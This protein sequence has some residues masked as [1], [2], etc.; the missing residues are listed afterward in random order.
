MKKCLPYILVAIITFALAIG[1]RGQATKGMDWSEYFPAIPNC[2]QIIYPLYTDGRGN[3]NQSARYTLPPLKMS[4][5]ILIENPDA[6]RSRPPDC[7][8]IQIRMFVPRLAIKPPKEKTKTQNRSEKTDKI[9]KK[10]DKIL[11]KIGSFYPPAPKPR[12][13]TIN[14]FEATQF[15]QARTDTYDIEPTLTTIEV[16]LA[17]KKSVLFSLYADFDSTEKIAKS[18]DY[19]KLAAAM[20]NYIATKFPIVDSKTKKKHLR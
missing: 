2:G 16:R 20:H 5:D 15:Y 4:G 6:L 3:F 1:V 8:N 14:G 9:S 19:Q 7:G 12:R 18:I 10:T 13:F 17:A 11:K